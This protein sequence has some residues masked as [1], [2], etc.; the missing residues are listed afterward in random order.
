[1]KDS[2]GKGKYV[3]RQR[4]G[5]SI[6]R[7]EGKKGGEGPTFVTLPRSGEMALDLDTRN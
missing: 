5:G 4:C 1:M 7:M 2:R 3:H 6:G